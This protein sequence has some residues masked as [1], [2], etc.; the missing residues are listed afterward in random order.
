[1]AS[2]LLTV[3]IPSALAVGGA[4]IA[5]SSMLASSSPQDAAAAAEKKP[6]GQKSHATTPGRGS[7]FDFHA[8]FLGQTL[9]YKKN[10]VVATV[11]KVG[12]EIAQTSA[13]VVGAEG[14]K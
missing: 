14:S 5:I 4:T 6:D 3:G 8:N 1:M 10:Q 11:K 7:V 2:K 13:K 9:S 12:D